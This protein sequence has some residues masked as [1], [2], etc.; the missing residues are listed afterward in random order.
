MN[1]SRSHRVLILSGLLLVFTGCASLDVTTRKELTP[2]TERQG[3]TLGL[4]AAGDRLQDVVTDPE[5]S[6]IN[7]ASGKLF[8]KVTLLPK[9]SKFMQP[10][11]IQSAYKVDYILAVGISDI[12]VSGDLNPIWFASLPLL[13]LKIY[14]PIVTF[15]PGVALDVI[16]RDARTGAVLMQKQV[17]ESSSDHFAPSNP[18]PKVRKLISLTISNALVSVLRDSQQ[19]IAVA[20]RGGR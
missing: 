13:V 19:S 4:Q 16:L 6:L 1:I 20:R 11:D 7:A 8:D 15:Q 12:S 5:N 9:E 10:Q 2:A 14:T 3:V 18:G 17:M